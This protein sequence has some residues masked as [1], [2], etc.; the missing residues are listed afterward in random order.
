MSSASSKVAKKAN[1]ATKAATK[2]FFTLSTVR[3]QFSRRLDPTTLEHGM[4]TV[5]EDVRLH[6]VAAGEGEPVVLVPGWPQSWYA[7][8]PIFPHLIEAGKR[9]YAI[10][11]RGFG[12]SDKP[13]QGYDLT[14]ASA[15]L[16]N[17]IEALGLSKGK[18][19]DVVGHDVGSW[20]THAHAVEYPEDVRRLVITD[21]TIPGISPL[22][23]G[24]FPDHDTNTRSWHFGFNRVDHLPEVLIQGHERQFLSWFFGRRKAARVWSIDAEAFEEYLRVFSLPGA[25]RSGL[26]YYR[27]VFSAEGQAR[28]AVRKAQKLRMP[29]LAIGGQDADSQNTVDTMK[30]VGS[31]VRGTVIPNV[32]HHLPEECPD[33][34][35]ALIIQFWREAGPGR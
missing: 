31:N 7:W 21:A 11:P 10:D 8:R 2:P 26:M 3:S 17:F 16:H 14:T 18:G 30:A 25:V 13:Q 5:A 23:P 12:D 32:G 19:V 27:H 15:D 28:Q 29:I 24:G 33:E 20:I 6:F 4:V 35:S 22:P 1:S 34:L 9:V